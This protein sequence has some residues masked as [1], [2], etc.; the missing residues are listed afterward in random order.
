MVKGVGRGGGVGVDA[1]RWVDV[2]WNR[3]RGFISFTWNWLKGLIIVV[4]F[5]FVFSLSWH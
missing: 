1:G 2:V 4:G 5:C 3:C